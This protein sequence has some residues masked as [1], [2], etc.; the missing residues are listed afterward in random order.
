MEKGDVVDDFELTDQHGGAVRL[1]D[2]LAEGPLVFFF[3]PKAMT[4]G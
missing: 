2:L 1:T 3:Y 4:T